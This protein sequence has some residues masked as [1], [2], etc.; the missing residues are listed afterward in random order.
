MKMLN[1]MEKIKNCDNKHHIVV[2]GNLIFKRKVHFA[3]NHIITAGHFDFLCT[4][5]RFIKEIDGFTHLREKEAT[6]W[7]NIYGVNNSVDSASLF[8]QKAYCMKKYVEGSVYF[9]G[10]AELESIKKR[11]QFLKDLKLNSKIVAVKKEC[12]KLLVDWNASLFL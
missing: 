9:G 8:F 7:T 11:I 5:I 12:D 4:Y 1:E 6:I 2:I 3:F 10:L